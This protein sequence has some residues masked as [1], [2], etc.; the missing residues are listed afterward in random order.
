MFQ[1]YLLDL[2]SLCQRRR[3]CLNLALTCV[4]A[5]PISSGQLHV[6]QFTPG[7]G[8]RLQW[9]LVIR[10]HFSALYANKHM[11][12]FRLQRPNALLVLTWIEM[13]LLL[14]PHWLLDKN[15]TLFNDF[16]DIGSHFMENFFSLWCLPMLCLNFTEFPEGQIARLVAKVT[17]NCGYL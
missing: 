10:S 15:T 5:D 14:W 13:K 12:H 2:G 16:G 17:A 8:M 1:S 11:H 3:P 7:I 6:R 9:P 4:L